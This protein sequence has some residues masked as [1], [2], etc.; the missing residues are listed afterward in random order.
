DNHVIATGGSAV[1]S[2]AAMKHLAAYGPIVYLDADL[3]ELRRRIHNYDS[4]G[5]ARREDQSFDDGFAE[6]TELYRRYADITVNCNQTSQGDVLKSLM[7]QLGMSA[8]D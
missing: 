2:D 7:S 5:I 3:D 1:Y 6:R 8:S 4:R